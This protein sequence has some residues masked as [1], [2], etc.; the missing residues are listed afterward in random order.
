YAR[1][2]AAIDEVRHFAPEY[3]GLTPRRAKVM[4]PQQRLFLDAVR[5]TLEDAG[6]AA[7]PFARQRTGTFVGA[8]VSDFMDILTAR[9]RTWQ[10]LEGE[11]GRAVGLTEDARTAVNEDLAPMQ[12]YSMVGSLNNMI[13]A[14][15]NQCLD[16][17]GPAFTTD[18][19]CSSALVALH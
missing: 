17:G 12:A 3:F 16:L 10:A 8:A 15:V 14:N 11:F 4:D 9:I 18:A 2:I 5:V 6:Y 7:R 19:A 13:A 1:K